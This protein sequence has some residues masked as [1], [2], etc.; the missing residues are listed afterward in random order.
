MVINHMT[1]I[2]IIP[3]SS[4]IALT[5]PTLVAIFGMLLQLSVAQQNQ[6]NLSTQH[7]V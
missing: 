5:Q 4:K 2:Y 7:M 3:Q 6:H 1:S